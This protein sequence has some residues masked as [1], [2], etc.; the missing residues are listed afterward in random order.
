MESS[1]CGW[2]ILI[3]VRW[4][5]KVNKVRDNLGGSGGMEEDQRR[6]W[7]PWQWKRQ[8]TYHWITTLMEYELSSTLHMAH[9]GS[10][11]TGYCEN[12]KES[13]NV[14]Q[15]EAQGGYYGQSEGA[16]QNR[17]LGYVWSHWCTGTHREHWMQQPR[18]EEVPVNLYP[19]EQDCLGNLMVVREE[20]YIPQVPEEVRAGGINRPGRATPKV[21]RRGKDWGK[22]NWWWDTKHTS[23]RYTSQ[24]KDS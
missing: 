8:R 24:T 4:L 13:W 11:W 17:R 18:L 2:Q 7:V 9:P 16:L 19:T 6:V 15:L 3:M 1:R 23:N 5:V 14:M 22:C 10:E 20:V 12:G 21:E